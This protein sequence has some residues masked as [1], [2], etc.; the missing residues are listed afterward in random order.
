MQIDPSNKVVEAKADAYVPEASKS[1]PPGLVLTGKGVVAKRRWIYPREIKGKWTR[2]R[3]VLFYAVLLPML[4]V[5]PWI[6][7]G[8]QQAVIFDVP[9]RRVALFGQLFFPQDTFF[10][11]LIL[12]LLALA[13][14]L[15]TSLWGRIWCGFACPQTVFIE[16]LF[17]PIELWLE[18]TARVRKK[19]DKGPRNF[20]YWWRK[21]VKHA[22]F[23]LVAQAISLTFV[24]YFHGS[25]RLV[26]DVLGFEVGNPAFWFTNILTAVFY[27]DFAIFREQFC[28]FVCPYA[29]FQGV[30]MDDNSMVVGYDV[31]RG[32]SR[33]K[34]KKKTPDSGDCI[35]CKACVAVCPT[36]IDIRNGNQLECI[37]CSRC[38]DACDNIMVQ[39]GKPKGL[40]RFDAE[41]RLRRGRE[42]LVMRPRPLIYASLMAVLTVVFLV[43]L[44][45]RPLFDMVVLR[46][47]NLTITLPD[48]RPANPLEVKVMNKDTQAH[49]FSF[50]LDHKLGFGEL[51]VPGSPITLEPGERKTLPAMLVL[52]VDEA[53]GL[54][55]DA[56]FVIKGGSVDAPRL[57][58][59]H[60]LSFM[61]PDPA[62]RGP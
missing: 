47:R 27:Y 55:M 30:L 53:N 20:D 24:A 50:E 17:R 29:R 42:R 14:F 8:G 9:A 54:A 6:K 11:F 5:L 18:G 45:Q 25:E 4:F 2:I 44:V 57:N 61:L 56:R 48:G 15:F 3:R 28:M 22:V 36:G 35:D 52:G 49:V 60:E 62:M 33:G 58:V 26:R 46:Q 13:L 12:V 7:I 23:L 19:R 41:S 34:L 39:I 32:E 1:D 31:G 43:A 37:S 59:E 16:G 51:I 40:I 10:L 21:V 38:I